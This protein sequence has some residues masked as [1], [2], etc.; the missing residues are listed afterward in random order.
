V[1][2]R[3]PWSLLPL[4]VVALA[5]GIALSP[6]SAAW[7]DGVGDRTWQPTSAPA[8]SYRLAVGNAVLDLRKLPQQTTDRTVDLTLAVG[9]VHVL[10]PADLPVTV[11]AHVQ[12]GA[13][14]GSGPTA[15]GI[16]VD[17]TV[18]LDGT[19]SPVT[20]DVHL[21]DGTVNVVRS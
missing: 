14:T 18:T 6:T 7:S 4:L 16:G 3:A 21:T 8:P 12:Y 2:R 15:S 19:G 1:A 11:N 13:I 10:V 5:G 20:V 9:Q 17:R